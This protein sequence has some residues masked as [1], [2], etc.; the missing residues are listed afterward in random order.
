MAY[1]FDRYHRD[2]LYWIY[3]AIILGLTIFAIKRDNQN[4]ESATSPDS[5]LKADS[6]M[7]VSIQDKMPGSHRITEYTDS[8]FRFHAAIK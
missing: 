6:S 7:T 3:P 4:T 1:K 2:Y 8:T 5:D